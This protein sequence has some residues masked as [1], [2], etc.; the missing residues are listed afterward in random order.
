MINANS[1]DI[2][3]YFDVGILLGTMNRY[4]INTPL[5]RAHFIAQIAVESTQLKDS[6][7]RS[8]RGVS[9]E[10]YFNDKYDDR[11][12]L[13]N[14]AEGDGALF[15]GRGLIQLT[16]RE[17]YTKFG[18]KVAQ[19]YTTKDGATLVATDPAVAVESACWFWA[20]LKNLNALADRDSGDEISRRINGSG[21][22]AADL[23]NRR[24]WQ[25]RA[26][27]FLVR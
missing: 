3:R 18:K 10:D 17:N 13:G 23:E 27:F 7:E 12:D 1:A 25:D 21:I 9:S 26:K 6:S 14:T 11:E 4:R 15:R 5:R 22:K 19:D 2:N 24:R 16:G 20:V 8:P